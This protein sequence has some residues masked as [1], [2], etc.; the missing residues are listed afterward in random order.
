LNRRFFWPISRPSPATWE[1]AGQQTTSSSPV[2]GLLVVAAGIALLTFSLWRFAPAARAQSDVTCSPEYR[3]DETLPT[4][5]R[6]EMCWEPRALE[7]IVLHDITFTPPGGERRLIIATASLAQV[8][9]P[10]DDNGA[11]FHDVTDFG[12]GGIYLSNLRAEECVDGDLLRLGPKN[13]LCKQVRNRGLAQR[14]YARTLQGYELSLFSISMSGD[15]NYIIQWVFKD[16]GTI[17]PIVGAAG[18]LQRYGSDP[19]HGWRTGPGPVVPISHYHNYWWRLDFD[20]DGMENDLV[21]EIQLNPADSAR[22]RELAVTPLTVESARTH[23]PSVQR[24]WRIRDKQVTNAEGRSISYHIEALSSGHDFIGPTFEPFARND[25]YVT[26]N[27]SCEKYPSHNPALSGCATDVS[28][29]VNGESVDGEDLVVW[30][31]ITLHHLPRAED[32]TWMDI[33]WD[34]FT[35]VPRDWTAANPLDSRSNSGVI[36]TPTPIPGP[37]ETVTPTATPVLPEAGCTNILVNGGFEGGEAWAVGGTPF[38][39]AYVL[40]PVHRGTRAMRAGVPPEAENRLTYSSFFQR[41]EIP[42]AVDQVF[43]QYQERAGGASDGADT[44]EVL[45][46]SPT[47]GLL[48]ALERSTVSGDETWRQRR[49]DLSALR[50]QT[51]ILY[52]NVYNNGGDSQMWSYYDDVE[53]LVCSPN[54]TP[55][56]GVQPLVASPGQMMLKISD[57]PMTVDL[58]LIS[59]ISTTLTWT[60]TT[61]V[62]WLSI[63]MVESSMPGTARV[64][65]FAPPSEDAASSGNVLFSGT[66]DPAAA[67]SVQFVVIPN[68]QY[69]H[70]LPTVMGGG[71]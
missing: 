52:F 21:E 65:V 18:Q 61:D 48:R 54:G 9:V 20:I 44:R 40:N 29:F 32:E 41:V 3:I 27:R 22:R 46:L 26:R 58:A 51:A 25:F 1:G 7:G 43:L 16:D 36:A 47:F 38:R 17:E 12:F 8:H 71:D 23:D 49:F 11:R 5:A 56:A 70:Y 57:L 59:P 39:A 33:H 35:I 10:Y 66:D 30:Y 50:G 37:G 13:A 31:G 2:L 53:L 28:A 69:N 19:L 4:G 14:Y 68:M 15:Y 62:P 34:G 6:W 60:A 24:S 55:V 63:D 45:I 42:L 64:T 67:A